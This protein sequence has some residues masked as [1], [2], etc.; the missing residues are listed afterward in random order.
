M[1]NKKMAQDILEAA[2]RY[3][4][5]DETE[6][7][8]NGGKTFSTRFTNNYISQNGAQKEY[9]LTVRV[10]FG[11]QVGVAS[12]NIFDGDHL[13]QVVDNA[14]LAAKHS[15][16]DQEWTAVLDPQAYQEQEQAYNQQT[17]D[18][19]PQEKSE[20]LAPILKRSIDQKL[21]SA[22]MLVNGDNMLAV[23]NS[24]QLFAYQAWTRASFTYTAMADQQGSAWTEFHSHDMRELEIEALSERAMERAFLAQNPGEIEPGSYTVV[25]APTAVLELVEFLNYLGFGGMAYEEN[26]SYLSGKVGQT[27]FDPRI[28]LIDD[29]FCSQVLGPGFDYEGHPKQ[30]LSLI[31]NGTIKQIAYD[32]RIAQQSGKVSTGHALMPPATSGPFPTNVILQAGDTPIEEMIAST[33]RGIYVTRLWY[34]N[35]VDPKQAIITGM[36]R[37]GTFLIEDGKLGRP[38]RNMRYNQSLLQAFANLESLGDQVYGFQGY[39]GKLAVPALKIRDFCFTGISK[40]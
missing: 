16:P 30:A 26:R 12:C 6:V 34:S 40:E 22:G 23:M 13:K 32:R 3:S 17:I 39:L 36:T 15:K 10:A 8:L 11:K 5:A 14:C 25:L 2:I 27:I 20:R 9:D 29:P 33:E 1:L 24:K 38:L 35:V 7:I 19:T 31:E 18:Y 4:P 37:D 21:T 28:N